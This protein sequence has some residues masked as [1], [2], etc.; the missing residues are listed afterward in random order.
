MD[1]EEQEVIVLHDV[2]GIAVLDGIDENGS[3]WMQ[4]EVDEFAEQEPGEC[5]ICGAE[6]TEGWVCLDGGDEVCDE[7]VFF[8]EDEDGN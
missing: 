3:R 7:H 4:F 2:G 1:T 5:S 6:M 8:E